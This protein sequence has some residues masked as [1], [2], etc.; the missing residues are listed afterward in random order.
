[1]GK[2]RIAVGTFR[3]AARYVLLDDFQLVIERID[4]TVRIERA[5]FRVLP[6]AQELEELAAFD[7]R[8]RSAVVELLK[9]REFHEIFAQEHFE[10]GIRFVGSLEIRAENHVVCEHQ[11][12]REKQCVF[13]PGYKSVKLPPL[14]GDGRIAMRG[15]KISTTRKIEI[16]GCTGFV[17]HSTHDLF[18]TSILR[19]L[20]G[21]NYS[22]HATTARRA[23]IPG[24]VGFR[25]A[26]LSIVTGVLSYQFRRKLSPLSTGNKIA[27]RLH[28]NQT[29]SAYSRGG[30]RSLTN[31]FVKLGFSKSC[32]P[33][34][35]GDG[36]CKSL[37]ER[38]LV[39]SVFTRRVRSEAGRFKAVGCQ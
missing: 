29:T 35:F 13:E 1:L 36:T 23:L 15:R 37:G 14:A 17:R 12:R 21:E 4:R 16:A 20:A 32:S 28:E 5:E 2:E 39:P 34:R 24:P 11:P 33:A 7:Q 18:R 25:D 22:G 26:I 19:S 30:D 31:E 38:E 3:E 10:V 8:E 6:L 27:Q 9:M